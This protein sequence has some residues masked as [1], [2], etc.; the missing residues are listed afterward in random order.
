MSISI[1]GAMPS[2]PVSRFG[3]NEEPRTKN[4]PA[5]QP[6]SFSAFQFFSFSVFFPL[7]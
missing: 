3:A 1:D 2:N 7:P 6:F 5:F 4:L